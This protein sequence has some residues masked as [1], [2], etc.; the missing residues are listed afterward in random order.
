MIE[1][2]IF[3]IEGKDVIKFVRDVDPNILRE[4][5]LTEISKDYVEKGL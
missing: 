2:D 3:G 4:E 1:I 5:K